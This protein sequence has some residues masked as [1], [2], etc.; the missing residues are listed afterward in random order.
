MEILIEVLCEVVLD[1]IVELITNKKVSK[2]IRC[3]LTIIFLSFYLV[4]IALIGAFSINLWPKT[5][6]AA[7]IF[8]V[9]DLLLIIGLILIVKKVVSKQK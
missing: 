8:M 3:P 6:I 4:I 5:L 7:I 2:W 9:I 1:G